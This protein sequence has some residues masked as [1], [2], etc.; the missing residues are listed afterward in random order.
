MT[1]VTQ[2][3]RPFVEAFVLRQQFPDSG[4]DVI[5]C[6]KIFQIHVHVYSAL[7]TVI[8][9]CVDSAKISFVILPSGGK[10]LFSRRYASVLVQELNVSID[11]GFVFA[12][13][14]V[15]EGEQRPD[16]AASQ[17]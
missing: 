9:V 3:A 7:I 2:Q 11:L 14:E 13:A 15:F 16:S 6:V 1:S 4:A 10:P 12:A 8:N 5:K 17:V